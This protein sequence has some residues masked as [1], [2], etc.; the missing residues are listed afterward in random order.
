MGLITTGTL[1]RVALALALVHET[2]VASAGALPRDRF[3]VEIDA[4]PST[5]TGVGADRLLQ[6]P[7]EA[8]PADVNVAA[9]AR[10]ALPG[11]GAE[12]EGE[13]GASATY[14][15]TF[16]VCSISLFS[17]LCLYQHFLA[18]ST[19]QE[20]RRRPSHL[21]SYSLIFPLLHTSSYLLYLSLI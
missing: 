19:T 17:L 16:N 14:G 3:W 5:G 6:S 1:L 15:I 12:V 21:D 7:I 4:P 2:Q 8:P 20:T 13:V 11:E 18:P 9:A 10:V